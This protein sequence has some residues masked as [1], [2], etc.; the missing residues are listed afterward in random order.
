MPKCIKKIVNKKK[1]SI[2]NKLYT[3]TYINY[4]HLHI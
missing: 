3:P 2:C 1:C 4:M